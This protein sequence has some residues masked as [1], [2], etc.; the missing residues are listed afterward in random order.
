MSTV[1]E[2]RTGRFPRSTIEEAVRP[3]EEDAPKRRGFGLCL[4]G[5]GYRATLYHLGAARRLHE[6][7]ALDR[8]DTISSVSGGSI[9]A[10]KLADLAMERG[11]DDG[12]LIEDFDEVAEPVRKLTRHDLRTTSMVWP[13]PG[14]KHVQNLLT[15]YG[16]R[17]RLRDLP[18]RPDF[19]FCATDMTYGI[20]W[21]FSRTMSGSYEFRDAEDPDDWPVA[22]AVAASA[23]FPPLFR[24]LPVHSRLVGTDKK[25][26]RKQVEPDGH[27][28]T[29]L[30][31]GG[32]YDN[33]GLEP[34][35]K[36][37]A[38]VLVS[39]AGAPMEKATYRNRPIKGLLRYGTVARGQTRALRLRIFNTQ[40][41]G[42]VYDGAYWDIGTRDHEPAVGYSKDLID[43]HIQWI[44]TDLDRFTKDEQKILENHGYWSVEEQFCRDRVRDQLGAILADT[45]PEPKAPHEEFMDEDRVRQALS[46]SKSRFWLPRMLHLD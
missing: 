45:V 5:G 15:R 2:V 10:A 43:K 44:R 11:W 14:A 6:L 7:G 9:F 22:F 41:E 4:S 17:N 40:L 27:R 42:N 19:V 20:C 16:T 33:L 32:V 28:S 25:I 23:C 36:K 18:K 29:Y 46:H 12:L 39:D 26:G 31:D 38:Q 34:V 24:P 30:S 13:G 3:A 8:V 37:R 35:W 21:E 1:P